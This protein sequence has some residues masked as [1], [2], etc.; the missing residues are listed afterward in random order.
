[1]DALVNII[2]ALLVG[3]LVTWCLKAY[4]RV[5]HFPAVLLGILVGIFVLIMDPATAIFHIEDNHVDLD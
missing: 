3:W 5:P 4:M 1:M 2:C